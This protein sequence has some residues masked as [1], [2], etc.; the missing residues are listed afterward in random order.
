MLENSFGR[1]FKIPKGHIVNR[2]GRA[3]IAHS[4]VTIPM[5][6]GVFRSGL[7]LQL[8]YS[9][10]KWYGLYDLDQRG[11]LGEVCGDD[12][13]EERVPPDDEDQTRKVP[14][15]LMNI[16]KQYMCMIK[17]TFPIQLRLVPIAPLLHVLP[18]EA[19]W[20]CHTGHRAC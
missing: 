3:L 13:R 15:A 1:C 20:R 17:P 9:R 14:Y 19:V 11:T 4:Y 6:S 2:A 8:A 16:T 18:F 12:V 7:D 5:G 10:N